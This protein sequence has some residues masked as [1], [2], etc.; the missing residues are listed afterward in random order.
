MLRGTHKPVSSVCGVKNSIAPIKTTLKD[1]K[2]SFELV[3]LPN[4]NRQYEMCGIP[5]PIGYMIDYAG[6]QKRLNI[7][8]FSGWYFVTSTPCILS[9]IN[10]DERGLLH[11]ASI[12]FVDRTGSLC[13]LLVSA[14][15]VFNSDIAGILRKHGASCNALDGSRIAAYFRECYRE[16]GV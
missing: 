8:M 4:G 5:A 15:S 6:V 16:R 7:R 14:G 12:L 10:K 2:V 1:I 3:D 11:D 13:K 9:T